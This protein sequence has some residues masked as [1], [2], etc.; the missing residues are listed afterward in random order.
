MGSAALGGAQAF[1]AM[2]DA[3]EDRQ[4]KRQG[5]KAREEAAVWAT[6]APDCKPIPVPWPETAVD[7]GLDL[8]RAISALRRGSGA[9]G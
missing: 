2:A 1:E 7:G 8:T 9:F 3:L 4:R 6:M 5:W